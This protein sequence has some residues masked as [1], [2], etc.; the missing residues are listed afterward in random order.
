MSSTIAGLTIGGV[1]GASF[2]LAEV[3]TGASQIDLKSAVGVGVFTCGIVWWMAKK[4]QELSDN[5]KEMKRD[6]HGIKKKL[7]MEDE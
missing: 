3:I 4:F 7:N 6:I 1:T 2:I 5:Q